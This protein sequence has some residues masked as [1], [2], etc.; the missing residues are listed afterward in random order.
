MWANLYS[1]QMSTRN[2]CYL[3]K[4]FAVST[5]QW[6]SPDPQ[7]IVC[8][9][10]V[11]L[12]V[13]PKAFIRL[14]LPDFETLFTLLKDYVGEGE[15]VDVFDVVEHVKEHQLS[16]EK[17]IHGWQEFIF[18]SDVQLSDDDDEH[19]GEV[20]DGTESGKEDDSTDIEDREHA[21]ILFRN[22][23]GVVHVNPERSRPAERKEGHR[24][25]R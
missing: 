19:E 13:N 21:N 16:F 23:A 25:R 6:R 1:I 3:S 12:F 18:D 20:E 2:E 4:Y 11:S 10:R 5:E 24:R 17:N 22:R 8:E 15:H 7:A 9:N 14:N